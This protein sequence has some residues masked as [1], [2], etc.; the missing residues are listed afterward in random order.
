MN[1]RTFNRQLGSLWALSAIRPRLAFSK[2]RDPIQRIGMSTV[3]FRSRFKQT[4][5]DVA[6]EQAL[7]LPEVPRYFSERFGIRHV[8]FWSRHFDSTEPAYLRDLRA[9]VEKEGSTLINTQLDEKYQLSSTDPEERAESLQLVLRWVDI[10]EALGSRA[11]RVNPGKG[12]PAHAIEALRQINAVAERKGIVLMTENHFGMAMDPNLHVQ[13]VQEVGD[14]TYTLPDFGN[15]DD[16]VRYEALRTV[17][18]YAYQVSAKTMDFSPTMEHVSYD[19]DRCMKIAEESGFT[20]IYSLEQ[21]SRT[22]TTVSDEAMVE[23]MIERIKP[24]C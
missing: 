3:T 19:F 20:G 14:N 23:W 1:R 15:Y 10:A 11:I 4:N 17:M 24:Y 6:P 22:P 16:E 7:T 8:E 12:E 5:E 9:V 2:K 13:L 18:P 21:W